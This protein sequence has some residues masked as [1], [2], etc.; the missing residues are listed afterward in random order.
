MPN[1]FP[2][3]AE[4]YS[5]WLDLPNLQCK[6]SGIRKIAARVEFAQGRP[7]TYLSDSVMSLYDVLVLILVSGA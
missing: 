4:N 3:C 5:R 1:K 7:R 6:E 2:K